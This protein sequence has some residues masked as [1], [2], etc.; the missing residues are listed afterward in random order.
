MRRHSL[1]FLKF[2]VTETIGSRGG[3][4]I[5]WV[6]LLVLE[7]E[8]ARCRAQ[9]ARPRGSDH[10]VDALQSLSSTTSHDPGSS[11]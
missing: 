11:V 5:R 1:H 9:S 4:G 2:L 6:T 10:S 8:V 3:G 7:L